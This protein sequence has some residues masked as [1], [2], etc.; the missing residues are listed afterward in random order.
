SRIFEKSLGRFPGMTP[1]AQVLLGKV[2][3]ISLITIAFLMAMSSLGINLTALAVL[4]GALGVGLGFGLQ[5][6][7]SN[8]ISGLILLMDRSIKPG[9]VIEVGDTY[10]WINK[11]AARYTSVITRDGREHLIPNEDMI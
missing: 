1:S 10:G 4:G 9:D 2:T 6:V 11:L 8:L 5:T 7:V 3:R